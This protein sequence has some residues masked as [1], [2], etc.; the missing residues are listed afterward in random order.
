MQRPPRTPDPRRQR[1]EDLLRHTV[2]DGTRQFYADGRRVLDGEAELETA[3][4][5][6]FHCAREVESAVRGVFF[7][8]VLTEG[9]RAKLNNAM[10]EENRRREWDPRQQLLRE[11]FHAAQ[12]RAIVARLETPA[13]A[14]LEAAWLPFARASGRSRSATGLAGLAHRPGLRPARAMEAPHRAIWRAFEELLLALLP[15]LEQRVVELLARVTE[16]AAVANPSNGHVRQ[17]DLLPHTYVVRD[18][19]LK[20]AGPSWLGPL[21]A[22]GFFG[23]PEEALTRDAVTGTPLLQEWQPGT[24]LARIAMLPQCQ[25]K[26]VEISTR[27][28]WPHEPAAL[29]LLGAVSVLPLPLRARFSS[30]LAVWIR[31]REALTFA[32]DEIAQFAAALAAEGSTSEAV[33][34]AEALLHLEADPSADP[35]G[36][37]RNPRTRLDGYHYERAVLS[38][39]PALTKANPGAAFD[40]LARLLIAGLEATEPQQNHATKNDWSDTWRPVLIRSTTH[41]HEHLNALVDAIVETAPVAAAT[42]AGFDRV[43]TTLDTAGWRICRRISLYVATEVHPK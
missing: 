17:L 27:V 36:F 4:N 7:Q 39:A 13:R 6:L 29:D 10:D 22:A 40:M 32:G 2:S 43:T 38:I 5:V 14:E 21:D 33:T 3:T 30:P 42:A 1:I 8:V 31:D 15:H 24:Y 18:E 34:I 9:D 41:G 12:V 35:K 37:T 11:P 20:R 25:E 26:F 23:H 28:A 19:F 16:L